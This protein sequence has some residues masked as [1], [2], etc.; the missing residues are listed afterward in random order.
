MPKKE[1]DAKEEI[2]VRRRHYSN[3]LHPF[4]LF[5]VILLYSRMDA[6]IRLVIND[7]IKPTRAELLRPSL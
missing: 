5:I 6:E 3:F 1:V 4:I 2:E 7:N